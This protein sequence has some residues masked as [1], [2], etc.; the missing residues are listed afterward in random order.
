[1][2]KCAY[3][4]NEIRLCARIMEKRLNILEILKQ[5]PWWLK[6][7]ASNWTHI[8][9]VTYS[10]GTLKLDFCEIYIDSCKFHLTKEWKN[11]LPS[12]SC[13]FA[14]HE[15]KKKMLLIV[16]VLSQIWILST[17]FRNLKKILFLNLNL[18]FWSIYIVLKYELTFI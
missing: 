13:K 9:L 5:F 8:I 18:W 11:F 16:I 10:E 12:R 2:L 4:S 1:M 17:L 3:Q 15:F 6:F 7:Y 14:R